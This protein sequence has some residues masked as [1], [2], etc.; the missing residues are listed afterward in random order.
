MNP[1]AGLGFKPQ[2]FSEAM[3]ST[4]VGLWFEVHA[5]N[6]MVDGG[7]RLAML[8][9]LRRE[10]PL[11]LHGVGL[12]VGSASEPDADLGGRITWLHAQARA[13]PTDALMATH[14]L[15]SDFDPL[16]TLGLR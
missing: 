13:T 5:E 3:A 9:Q 10:R 16:Q 12:S 15:M 1:T 8:E 11:S 4:A 2:H 14:P 6:Y 7:P